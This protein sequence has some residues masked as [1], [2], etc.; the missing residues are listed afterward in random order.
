[1]DGTLNDDRLPD[2]PVELPMGTHRIEAG[3]DEE[4]AVVWVGPHLDRLPEL[5]RGDHRRLFFNWY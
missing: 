2:E 5:G 1:M 3:S 4:I